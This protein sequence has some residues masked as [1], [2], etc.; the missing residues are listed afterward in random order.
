VYNNEATYQTYSLDVQEIN[1]RS[2]KV[3]Q[4]PPNPMK[5]LE[6]EKYDTFLPQ[7]QAPPYPERLNVKKAY[8]YEENELLGELKNLCVKI[9]LLQA[10]KYVPIY[11][12][13]IKEECIKRLGR[14]KKDTPTINVIGK[15]VDLMLGRI[16]VPKYLDPGS[17]LV[18]VHINNILIQNT[19]IDLGAA[20]NVMTKDTMLR[21]NLQGSLRNTSTMLQLADRSTVN[22]EGMLEDIMISIDSW[23]YPTDFLVLQTKSKFNGY[24]LILGRPWMATTD[25]Y[26]N[27]RAGNMTITNGKSKKQLVLYPPAQ[28]LMT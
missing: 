17:P 10:I 12:K 4:E 15:L 26:I 14:K 20:I 28:P 25:A 22:P 9:P 2:G 13:F 16:I 24:P 19:L 1:L 11:N 21:L 23:E 8:T 27:C 7:P 3:L 18:N 5:D 6:P